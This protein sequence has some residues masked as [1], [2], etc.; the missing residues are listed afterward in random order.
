M[1]KPYWLNKKIDFNLCYRMRKLL[2]ELHLYTVCE[3]SKCPNI[4]E[5]FSKNTATFM[6]LGNICTRNCLFCGVKKG[7]PQGLVDKDEPEKIKEAVKRLKLKYVVITSPTRDDLEDKGANQF[8]EVIKA[9]KSLN[10][11]EAVEVLVPD[12]C[13]D[14]ESIKKV[15]EANP[16]V[17]S[18]NIETTP[19]LY[20]FVRKGA[21]YKRSLKVLD[22]AKRIN[23]QVYTK[24]AIIL[25]L[26]EKEEEVVKVLKD[27]QKVNCDFLSIG[28]Y[29]APSKKHWPVKR[30]VTP[31]EFRKWEDLAYS[32]GFKK[33]KASPYIR[34]SYLAS[35]YLS[36]EK[37]TQ[38]TRLN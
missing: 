23:P 3:E 32:L 28:Q 1:R 7:N 13:G 19:F 4:S 26:G 33:V 21:F 2:K 8:Y 17:F 25:G 11:V 15:L 24:S 37:P 31:S 10:F 35:T 16:T 34:S 12:F 29:L 30:F 20:P 18:H 14:K 27:L 9:V 36:R 6:I 38:P 22:Y 5:C